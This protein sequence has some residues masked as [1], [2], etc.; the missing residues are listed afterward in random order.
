MARKGI[1]YDQV[2]NAA[3]A[4]KARGVE[5]TIQAVR[6]ELGG[7]GSYSTISQHLAK[8]RTEV[9]ERGNVKSLPPEAED[10]FMTSMT[11]IWNLAVK[12]ASEETAH[13]KQIAEDNEKMLRGELA[14]AA[15]EIGALEKAL[16]ES[17]ANYQKAAKKGVELETKVATMAGELEAT[18]RLYA[19]L[20]AS[21][22]KV[23]PQAGTQETP[24]ADTKPARQPKP[25]A[26]PESK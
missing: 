23:K 3:S 1:T 9:A 14:T 11:T 15:N 2:S 7:E 19:E 5:P 6:L 21:V 12:L 24:G 26:E 17:D 22:G 8:W 4:I 13:I 18:K 25:K 10:A 16:E 20:V